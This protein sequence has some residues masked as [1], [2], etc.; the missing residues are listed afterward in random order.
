MLNYRVRILRVADVVSQLPS[1]ALGLNPSFL[2]NINYNKVQR[3]LAH[4]Y[5]PCPKPELTF[6]TAKHA[7]PTFITML[8]QDNHGGLQVLHQ[9]NWVDV[10]PIHG[11]LVVNIGDFLQVFT[12]C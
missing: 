10:S 12:F 11:A 7:D 4:Y 6:G 2:D 9:N 1:E 3:L 8:L 5:P